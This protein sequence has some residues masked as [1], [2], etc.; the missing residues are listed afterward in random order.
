[1]FDQ[2]QT[3]F[4][5]A[6]GSDP[7]PFQVRLADEGLPELLEVPTGLGK[8]HGSVLAW[9]FRRRYHPDL[10]VRSGTARRLVYVLPMRVLVEQT[11]SSIQSSLE[12]LGLADEV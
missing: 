6:T 3:L 7:Y 4:K 8:T 11:Y 9:L 5:Q 1:M 2:F 12:R 10:T